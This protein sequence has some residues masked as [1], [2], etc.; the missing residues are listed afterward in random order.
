VTPE[1]KAKKV[2]DSQMLWNLKSG[3]MSI[4][5][6]SNLRYFS[7]KSWEI[8]FTILRNELKKFDG[9]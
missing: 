9:F 4:A 8:Q 2:R 1:S 6:D 3:S 7:E 5:F